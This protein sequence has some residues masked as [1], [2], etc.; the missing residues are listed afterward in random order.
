MSAGVC[1]PR[2]P[3]PALT[4]H[5]STGD[6]RQN[7]FVFTLGS[8]LLV[9]RAYYYL[10]AQGLLMVYHMGCW[11]WDPGWPCVLA[12]PP[13]SKFFTFNCRKGQGLWAR[14]QST[15]QGPITERS[16]MAGRAFGPLL[17]L[18]GTVTAAALHSV[19][20]LR[21]TR[22]QPDCLSRGYQQTSPFPGL[23]APLL[24][25]TT[26]I[27]FPCLRPTATAEAVVSLDVLSVV[28]ISSSCILSTGEK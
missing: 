21:T 8:Q 5:K 27:T 6:L 24:T 14:L 17:S 11:G 13:Q 20:D 12:W 15:A 2:P 19:D 10:S 3:S 4:A 25:L 18:S 26:M 23:P 22:H 7:S 28:M 1:P 16:G 9:L